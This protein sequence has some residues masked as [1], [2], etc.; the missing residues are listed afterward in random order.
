V[1]DLVK[2]MPRNL[3]ADA[4]ARQLIRAIFV[5][6]VKTAKR[7]LVRDTVVLTLGALVLLAGLM[8]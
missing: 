8:P 1:I 2:V 6:S 5:Q 7:G 4:I 3:A